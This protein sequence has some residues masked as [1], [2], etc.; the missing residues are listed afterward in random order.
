M[1]SAYP[2]S[3]LPIFKEEIALDTGDSYRMRQMAFQSKVG[4][5]KI[6]I[7]FGEQQRF[8]L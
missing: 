2:G 3:T 6:A 5:T 7:D 1:T 4:L 8:L